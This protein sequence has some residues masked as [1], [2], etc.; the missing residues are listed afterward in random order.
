MAPE[1]AGEAKEERVSG[2]RKLKI[3][4]LQQAH[5]AGKRNCLGVEGTVDFTETQ[6]I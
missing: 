3:G 6:L 1:L 5:N 2:G 4:D